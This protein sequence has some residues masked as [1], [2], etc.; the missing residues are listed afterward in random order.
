MG[1][2]FPNLRAPMDPRSM[3]LPLVAVLVFVYLTFLAVG[4]WSIHIYTVY[5]DARPGDDTCDKPYLCEWFLIWGIGIIIYTLMGIVASALHI[6]CYPFDLKE[7]MPFFCVFCLLA[8]FLIAWFVLGI[9]WLYNADEQW[10]GA[11][12]K[13]GKK[14]MIANM[15]LL[16][17]TCC[18][19]CCA[20]TMNVFNQEEEGAKQTGKDAVVNDFPDDVEIDDLPP[21]D[22][23]DDSP[24]DFGDDSPPDFGDPPDFGEAP[25]NSAE[26]E[27]PGPE[28]PFGE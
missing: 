20:T 21:L 26:Q 10:C 5:S 13:D 17:S 25:A 8:L 4:G 9:V 15:V 16:G 3:L 14:N 18:L 7:H 22:F 6:T 2:E 12:V 23:G 19:M 1:D 24:P 27:G 11:L 28:A